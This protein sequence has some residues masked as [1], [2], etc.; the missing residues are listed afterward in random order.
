MTGVDYGVYQDQN[1][2]KLDYRF[3]IKADMSKVP[4]KRKFVKVL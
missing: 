2:Y 4:Q 3:L 1:F